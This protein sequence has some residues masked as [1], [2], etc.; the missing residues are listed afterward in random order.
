MVVSEVAPRAQRFAVAT[1]VLFRPPG[2]GVWREG[3]TLNI[4]RTGVLFHADDPAPAARS[5][6]EF[7]LALPVFGPAPNVQ[8]HCIGQVAR[9]APE[10]CAGSRCAVA[11][12]I[13]GYRFLPGLNAQKVGE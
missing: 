7:I 5:A 9:V 1:T 4:S 13:E 2:S 6:M 3:W 8:V 11:T 10:A 12:T